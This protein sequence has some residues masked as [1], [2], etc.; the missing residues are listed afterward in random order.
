MTISRDFDKLRSLDIHATDNAVSADLATVFED[1]VGEAANSH[2]H[3]VLAVSV[4]SMEFQ[5]ALNHFYKVESHGLTFLV[6]GDGK[7]KLTCDVITISGS[8][9]TST[10][11]VGGQ[12]VELLAVLVGNNGASSS[13]GISSKCNTTLYDRKQISL[14]KWSESANFQLR[15][16]R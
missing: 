3:A 6:N 11:N 9:G 14:V 5:L 4:E 15:A 13:S 1:V 16:D 10:E 2:L 7:V 8:T 12:L